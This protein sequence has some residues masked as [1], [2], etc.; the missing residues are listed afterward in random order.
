MEVLGF[1]HIVK[2]GTTEG[3]EGTAIFD[4]DGRVVA[5]EILSDV[6]LV[7]LKGVVTRGL[8][9]AQ[10]VSRLLRG[11]QFTF[12]LD[13]REVSILVAARCVFVVAVY[14]PELRST[15]SDVLA[16]MR[17]EAAAIVRSIVGTSATGP[18]PGGGGESSGPAELALAELG[19]TPG[20][21]PGK[22]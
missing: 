12:P 10:L 13:D 7:A 11:E 4:R 6:D 17:D 8:R 14:K 18:P 15:A 22:A 21:K 3:V 16:T 2:A 1:D 20:I 19:I 5:S 9:G